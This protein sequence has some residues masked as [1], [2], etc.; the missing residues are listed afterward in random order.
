PVGLDAERGGQPPLETDRDVAQAE[1][2]VP[3]VEQ[4]PGDDADRVG[5]VDDP[6]PWFGPLADHLGDVEHHGYRAQPLGEPTRP[7]R[8]LAQQPEL[9]GQRLVNQPGRLATDPEL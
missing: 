2:A 6:G 9:A 3:G 8:L 5:E 4:G 7:G 1:R